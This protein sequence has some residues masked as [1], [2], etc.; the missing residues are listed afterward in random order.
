[1][2]CPSHVRFTLPVTGAPVVVRP[3]DGELVASV[4]R[5]VE[6]QVRIGVDD[7]GRHPVTLEVLEAALDVAPA[8]FVAA[9]LA[10]LVVLVDACLG[11]VKASGPFAVDNGVPAAVTFLDVRNFIA[12]LLG[13]P[14]L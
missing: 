13:N 14:F 4:A 1:M 9:E 11:E 6:E 3:G 5:V 12:V 10:F 7:L 2:V 8:A